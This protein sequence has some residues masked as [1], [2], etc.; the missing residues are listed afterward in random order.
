MGIDLSQ[1]SAAARAQQRR[2]RLFSRGAFGALLVLCVVVAVYA[3]LRA[4]TETIN[5]D[6]RK[7]ENKI[8]QHEAESARRD[9][10]RAADAIFRQKAIVSSAV[11][12]SPVYGAMETVASA[13]LPEVVLDELS[14]E[15]N[16]DGLMLTITMST[17]D[18]LTVARQVAALRSVEVIS[19]V[20]LGDVQRET[21]AA[22]TQRAIQF[23]VTFSITPSAQ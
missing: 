8:K 2:D 13:I 3:G 16:D 14:Y 20:S 9:V 11:D 5:G 12:S 1:T 10:A 7:V 18:L 17:S 4:Y 22:G 15:N 6:I 21:E 19:N 23:T